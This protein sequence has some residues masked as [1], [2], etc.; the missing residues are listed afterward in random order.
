MLEGLSLGNYLLLVDHTG[1][2]FREGKSVISAEVS[3]ILELLGSTAESSR[4]RLEKLTR[5]RLFGRFFAATR[6]RLRET[7]RSLGV[8][9]LANLSGCPARYGAGRSS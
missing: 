1:R 5:G 3:G 4:S 6:E 2:L 9:H 8:H 7:A